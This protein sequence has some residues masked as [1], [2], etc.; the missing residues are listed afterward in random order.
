MLGCLAAP[1]Q[2]FGQLGDLRAILSQRHEPLQERL[3]AVE[4]TL[5]EIGTHALDRLAPNLAEEIPRLT[6][7]ALSEPC[8]T[9]D[10]NRL[11]DI[12][13]LKGLLGLADGVLGLKPGRRQLLPGE[14]HPAIPCGRL[15]EDPPAHREPTVLNVLLRLGDPQR[16]LLMN[17]LFLEDGVA[18]RRPKL[19]HFRQG[20]AELLGL[21]AVGQ[22]RL[23]TMSGQ[24]LLPALKHGPRQPADEP[25]TV[26]M[27][28]NLLGLGDLVRLIEP[29]VRQRTLSLSD[30][31]DQH[32]RTL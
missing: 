28:A 12:A 22:R 2:G 29:A 8:P 11:F 20:P 6:A 31:Q 27:A 15:F 23:E 14:F 3:R 18:D 26:M 30:S 9:D 17:L 24:I 10:V 16:L 25:L 7:F 5:F 4:A 1:G 19:G 13:L 21:V 32:G